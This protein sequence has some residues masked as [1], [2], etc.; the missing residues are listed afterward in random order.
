MMF[1]FRPEKV[2]HTIGINNDV[3]PVR[4]R[5]NVI[6]IDVGIADALDVFELGDSYVICSSYTHQARYKNKKLVAVSCSFKPESSLS[7]DD[8]IHLNLSDLAIGY[9]LFFT[10]S[11][12]DFSFLP[13]RLS[14]AIYVP[15]ED[16]N[17]I[18]TKLNMGKAF[19]SLSLSFGDVL[20]ESSDKL[21][22]GWEPDGS[23]IIW[24]YSEDERRPRLQLTSYEMV[25][26]DQL[27]E[28][29][30]AKKGSEEAIFK[31]EWVRI[32]KEIKYAVYVIAFVS[33]FLIFARFI[34]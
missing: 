33:V 26:V 5:H 7:R 18:N 21:K 3:S 14:F 30:N 23:R 11:E 31:S 19:V 22:Y 27:N 20:G 1:V 34:R 24:N 25:F 2:S 13:A 32:L 16:Y 9:G 6:N 4:S 28:D 29:S 10:E 12:S 15:D 8:R 17:V